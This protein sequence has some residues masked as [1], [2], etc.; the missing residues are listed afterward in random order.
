MVIAASQDARKGTIYSLVI[1]SGD[2]A[3]GPL[4]LGAKSSETMDVYIQGPGT[5][6]GTVRVQTSLD[7]STWVDLKSGGA[8]IAVGTDSGVPVTHVVADYIRLFSGSAEGGAR[9]FKV[10]FHAAII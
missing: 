5:L 1:A 4:Y 10:K 7:G 6:T 9:T 3:S 2:Q 8:N